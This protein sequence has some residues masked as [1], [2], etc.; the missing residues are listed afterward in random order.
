MIVK[1][2]FGIVGKKFL[3][4]KHKAVESPVEENTP[5]Q[6]DVQNVQEVLEKGNNISKDKSNPFDGNMHHFGLDCFDLHGE[7]W[8]EEGSSK[9]IV[10]LIHFMPWKRQYIQSFLPE[11]RLAFARPRTRWK[12]V[13]ESL[14]KFDNLVFIVWG[15]NDNSNYSTYAEAR[16]IPIYRMEDG[17]IRSILLGAK[18]TQPLSLILDKR[19][20]YFNS[21]QESDIEYIINNSVEIFEEANILRAKKCIELLKKYQLSK[22]NDVSTKLILPDNGGKERILVVGQVDDD[23]SIRYG[24]DSKIT[25]NELVR[26]AKENNPDAEII[27]KPHPEVLAGFKPEQEDYN[28]VKDI[29]TIITDKVS[30]DDVLSNVNKVY[31]IT[32]LVGFEAILR[33]IPVVCYG[34]PFYAG[35]GLTIDQCEAPLRR[36]QNLTIEQLFYAAYIKYPRY[37][38]PL[39]N[40]PMSIEQAIFTLEIL[41]TSTVESS[42]YNITNQIDL[43][44]TTDLLPVEIYQEILDNIKFLENNEFGK[45][46][47]LLAQNDWEI[48]NLQQLTKLLGYASLIQIMPVLALKFKKFVL[49]DKLKEVLVYYNRWFGYYQQFLSENETKFFFENYYF[50]QSCLSKNR[51]IE[52]VPVLNLSKEKLT[53]KN[54]IYLLSYL[55]CLIANTEYKRLYELLVLVENRPYPFWF[56]LV[57]FFN[58]ATFRSERSGYS[59]HFVKT[60]CAREGLNCL[61][62]LYRK[63]IELLTNKIAYFAI[64]NSYEDLVVLIKIFLEEFRDSPANLETKAIRGLFN[65]VLNC[66]IN[67]LDMELAYEV[68]ALFKEQ[69]SVAQRVKFDSLIN[70]KAKNIN[71]WGYN[72][73]LKFGLENAALQL[74]QRSQNQLS[75]SKIK[76][77]TLSHQLSRVKFL[78]TASSIINS[79]PQPIYMKGVVVLCTLNCLNSLAMLAPSIMI[80]KKRG[81]TVINL[82][83][84]LI[85]PQYTKFP[86]I[87]DLINSV[88][89]KTTDRLIV[90]DWYI[91]WESRQVL[92]NGINFYQGIYESLSVTFRRFHIDINDPSIASSFYGLLQKCDYILRVC[93]KIEYNLLDRSNFPVVLISGNS[94]VAPYSVFRDFAL[95]RDNENLRYVSVNI[96]YENYYTNL[97]KKYSSSM[98]VVD[99]TLHKTCRAPFLAVKERFESWYT[100]EKDTPVV[101]EKVASLVYADRSLVTKGL[102]VESNETRQRIEEAKSSGKRIICCFGKILCDLAV[103]YD[104]GHGHSDIVD[105]INHTV[106]IASQHQDE[107]LLLIKPHPHEL[108]SEIAMDLT[109]TLR[110]VLP[111]ELPKNVIFLEHNSFNVHELARVI[112]LAVLWNGTSSLELTILGVPVIMCSYF[113]EY[114]YPIQLNYPRSREGY[115]E[116]LVNSFRIDA[117]SSELR[118]RAAALLY[119]MGT[120][121]VAIQNEYSMRSMTNDSVGVPQWV[122]E[123]VNSL[124]MNGDKNMELVADRIL[125]GIVRSSNYGKNHFN[126]QREV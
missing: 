107:I 115:V 65:P 20:I 50:A 5:P 26:I 103:P 27:Y 125:E 35:Y 15:M 58:S 23:A 49:F 60:Y 38:C 55:K 62:Q 2:I 97:S 122:D 48:D 116:L 88:N 13:K 40:K 16:N 10:I 111:K 105:W 41:K 44:N 126:N 67:N 99:M 73:C 39:S 124:L 14:D 1:N 61:N 85:E 59:K 117:P 32:S 53:D 11:F 42:L 12:I 89:A 86:L 43:V 74:I 4:N 120:N 45:F 106:Q 100:R 75:N 29:A 113:G 51:S 9:P 8:L 108:R 96:A 21:N 76:N 52:K 34:M 82:I 72:D 66:L 64:L 37:V 119:Y 101:A 18:H 94:H 56:K 84:S 68:Y 93:L 6:K 98:A 22:Y 69:F 7:N 114:D 54:L 57:N 80:L 91:N 25:S 118:N 71:Q 112:D 28:L 46:I 30:I 90:E 19:G 70:V 92:S 121:E 3:S 78:D 95:S 110:D 81:F 87:N 36:M 47:G 123:K 79:T 24:C 109:E 31:V 17:F 102:S 77:K 33:G 83:E 104:G 63:P